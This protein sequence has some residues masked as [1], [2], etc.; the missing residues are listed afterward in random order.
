MKANPVKFWFTILGNTG[1]HTLKIGDTIPKSVSSVTLPH[2][3]ID[4]KL[5]LNEHINIMKKHT[6][7]YMPPENYESF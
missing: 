5:N 1:S 6:I 3:T 2:I 4:S 7:N